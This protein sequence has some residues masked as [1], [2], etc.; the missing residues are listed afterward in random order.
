VPQVVTAR[1]R[2]RAVDE[3]RTLNAC[4][5]GFGMLFIDRTAMSLSP[6]PPPTRDADFLR[7]RRV[8]SVGRGAAD[9][10]EGA[11]REPFTV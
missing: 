3:G 5:P 7:V 9:C 11:H 4:P 8:R 6:M 1:P 10:D 2:A